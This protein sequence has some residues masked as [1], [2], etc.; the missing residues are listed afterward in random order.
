MQC[1]PRPSHLKVPRYLNLLDILPILP[2]PLP[3]PLSRTPHPNPSLAVAIS[4]FSLSCF[5]LLPH[6]S[7]HPYNI[8]HTNPPISSQSVPEILIPLSKNHVHH[9]IPYLQQRGM[10]PFSRNIAVFW[11]G[12]ACCVVFYTLLYTVGPLRRV[13][14]TGFDKLDGWMDRGEKVNNIPTTLKFS[15]GI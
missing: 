7:R 12:G 8:Q 3:P 11:L 13:I 9:T 14:F 2:S 5:L 15:R 10:L 6:P 1:S 4:S